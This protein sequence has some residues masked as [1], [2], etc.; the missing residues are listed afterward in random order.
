MPS[1][2]ERIEKLERRVDELQAE[3]RALQL[4]VYAN[5]PT[6]PFIVTTTGTGTGTQLDLFDNETSH[7]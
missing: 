3:I 1:Q 6:P 4:L 5:Q 2:K 7:G